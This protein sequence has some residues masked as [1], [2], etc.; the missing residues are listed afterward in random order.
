MHTLLLNY[1][2]I[3]KYA[4]LRLCYLYYHELRV[5]ISNKSYPLPSSSL[6]L[7]YPAN[8]ISHAFFRSTSDLDSGGSV[9]HHV[10]LAELGVV[11]V[12]E[13]GAGGGLAAD[14]VECVEVLVQHQQIHHVLGR[15]AG[16]TV[17]EVHDTVPIIPQ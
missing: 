4:S 1:T 11:V 16:H 10:G 5:H 7:R 12:E 14:S 6:F 9:G 17:R 2:L 3:Q 15:G 8:P 13:D